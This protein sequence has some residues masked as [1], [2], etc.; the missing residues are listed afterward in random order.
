MG[1]HKTPALSNTRLKKPARKSLLVLAIIAALATGLI[2]VVVGGMGDKEARIKVALAL[3]KAR[4]VQDAV[5]AYYKP[6]KSLPPDN[7]A[8]RLPNKE[9]QPYLTAFEQQ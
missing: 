4:Q 1:I 2:W 7:T 5:A 3:A 6:R 8:L 9:S